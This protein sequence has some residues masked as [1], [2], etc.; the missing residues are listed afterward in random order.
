MNHVLSTLRG[1]RWNFMV[2]AADVLLR[3]SF[4]NADVTPQLKTG[5][6]Y[7]TEQRTAA[8]RPLLRFPALASASR[9][10]AKGSTL[11]TSCSY[12]GETTLDYLGESNVILSP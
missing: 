7:R 5:R 4:S 12:N 1:I 10:V 2:L 8:P 6:G 11:L 9:C 3:L